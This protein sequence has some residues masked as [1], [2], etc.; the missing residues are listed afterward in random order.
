MSFCYSKV[1]ATTPDIKLATMSE[2]RKGNV[3][4]FI[5]EKHF[6]ECHQQTSPQVHWPRMI[7]SHANA[8]IAKKLEKYLSDIA[9]SEMR[10]SFASRKKKKT[11]KQTKKQTKKTQENRMIVE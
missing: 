9:A 8:F 3:F 11:K 6:T 10:S 4:L 2:G 5:R 7:V 1:A